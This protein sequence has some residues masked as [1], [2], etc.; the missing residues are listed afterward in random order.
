SNAVIA[1]HVVTLSQGN[2]FRDLYRVVP[3]DQVAVRVQGGATFDYQVSRVELVAPSAVEVMAATP[4]PELT[5]ITCAG[6]FDP[7]TRT[8]DKRLVVVARLLSPSIG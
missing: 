1:G 5:L 7:R 2:V 8:F 3:G 6:A 4:D